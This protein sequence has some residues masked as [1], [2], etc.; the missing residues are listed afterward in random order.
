MDQV[1]AI[2]IPHAISLCILEEGKTCM[3]PCMRS[4][5]GTKTLSVIHLDKGLKRNEETYL[6]AL[7]EDGPEADPKPKD[8]PIQV[9]KVLED[10]HNI[11][12]TELAKELPPKR[13]VDHHF[14]LITRQQPVIPNAVSIGHTGPSPT[15]CKLSKT[16]QEQSDI[17]H[18]YW[19]KA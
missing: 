14:E 7:V 5:K 18:D 2:P 10:S 1:K 9:E 15:A 12:P 8:L 19:E 13:E 11:M 16:W 3:V 6:A 4:N 17:A